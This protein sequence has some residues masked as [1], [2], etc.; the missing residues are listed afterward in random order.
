MGEKG[1]KNEVVYVTLFPPLSPTELEEMVELQI[2]AQEA[3]SED[4]EAAK[5]K[6]G[7][8]IAA[9]IMEG[10]MIEIALTSANRLKAY[11]RSNAQ[12]AARKW[13]L[14]QLG[15]TLR[16]A[17]DYDFTN[18]AVSQDVQRRMVAMQEAAD[19]IGALVPD[20]CKGWSPPE[21]LE[22]WPELPDWLFQPVRAEALRLNPQWGIQ[23]G[24]ALGN[25]GP[26]SRN[27]GKSGTT[28]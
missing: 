2:E 9:E 20:K 16:E 5:K 26:G 10:M 17:A 8:E 14:D 19:I 4:D 28:G 24:V 15:I 11:D 12:Q 7:V 18:D 25:I 21:E 6:S 13:L 3:E 27:S 1:S 22:D 23:G